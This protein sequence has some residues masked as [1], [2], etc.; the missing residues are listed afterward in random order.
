MYG[1]FEARGVGVKG[2]ER[3]CMRVGENAQVTSWPAN[4]LDL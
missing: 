4:L 3:R 2:S 1:G